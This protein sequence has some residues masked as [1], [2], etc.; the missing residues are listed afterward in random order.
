MKPK[1]SSS[2]FTFCL[3]FA[4]LSASLACSMPAFLEQKAT[5]VPVQA[6]ATAN[7]KPAACTLPDLAG[8]EAKTA[9]SM[10]AGLGLQPVRATEFSANVPAG[11]IAS[12]KPAAGTRIDPCQGEVTLMISLGAEP[13]KV[14]SAAPTKTPAPTQPP[15]PTAAATATKPA[16]TQVQA[17]A[18]KPAAT[19]VPSG[20]KLSDPELPDVLYFNNFAARDGFGLLKSPSW[21]SVTAGPGSQVS[22]SEGYLNV[23]GKFAFFGGG[24]FQNRVRILIGGGTYAIGLKEFSVFVNYQDEKNTLRMT[25]A[26]LPA[27]AG[28]MLTCDWYQVKGG[29]ETKLTTSPEEVCNGECDLEIELNNGTI[30]VFSNGVQTSSFNNNTYPTGMIGLRIE[31]PMG[32]PFTLDRVVVY[33][34]P[35]GAPGKTLFREDFGGDFDLSPFDGE[36]LSATITQGEGFFRYKTTAKKSASFRSIPFNA[37]YLPNN[38]SINTSFKQASGPAN[39]EVGIIFQRVD[40]NNLY[41]ASITGGGQ[42]SVSAYINGAWETL[43]DYTPAAGFRTGEASLLEVR[44]SASTYTLLVN[45]KQAAKFTD[46]R[47]ANGLFGIGFSLDKAGDTALIEYY[48]LEVRQ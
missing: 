27:G 15:A 34:I 39:T 16:A 12:Q 26:D 18:T 7:P 30:R 20:P 36:Y 29:T 14:P 19:L 28:L 23:E 44:A 24:A 25:C 2:L 42:I 10:V 9:E 6:S 46:K 8:M 33:E 22:S 43:V 1:H 47:L 21:K 4:L 32:K 37:V 17:T 38:F 5:E 45:G 41:Y 40:R 13:S 3:I 11:M 35:K 31:A 48:Q